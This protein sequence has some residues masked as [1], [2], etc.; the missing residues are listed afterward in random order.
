MVSSWPHDFAMEVALF[1][2]ANRQDN[3]KII[4]VLSDH[5]DTENVRLLGESGPGILK[6]N[7]FG[8]IN[9]PFYSLGKVKSY[10]HLEYRELV[11]FCFYRKLHYRYRR[12]LDIGGNLG[13]HSLVFAKLSHQKI[14]YFEPDPTHFSEA[15]IRFRANG[16]HER[17][18]MFNLA[19]SD[20]D[21]HAG[22]VRVVDN[23]T[24]SHLLGSK[25]SAYGPLDEF[26]VKVN[27]LDSQLAVGEMT[28]GKLDIE[29]SEA[30]AL[31]SISPEKWE[32]FDAIVEV[33]NHKNATEIMEMCLRLQ[34]KIFSQK[35]SWQ[36]V[37]SISDMPYNYKEG[38]III[39]K[40]LSSGELL[41]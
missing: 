29:G 14:S 23:T 25:S 13:L 11:L 40:T 27:R 12:F 31:A 37:R 28:L 5:I 33:T 15:E 36:N 18:E 17:I 38:S 16:V 7:G 21:G 35:I 4:E 3:S 1:L 22:F 10:F 2:E 6:L 39:S 32:N 24:A 26:S 34:L 30:S 20:F 8:E 41:S 9:F 19:I